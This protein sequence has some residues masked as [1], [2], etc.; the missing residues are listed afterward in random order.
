MNIEEKK[1][2]SS[3]TVEETKERDIPEGCTVDPE[4]GII[5]PPY[6]IHCCN[7]WG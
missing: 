5:W 4:T 1:K 3:E 6:G 7:H 2:E